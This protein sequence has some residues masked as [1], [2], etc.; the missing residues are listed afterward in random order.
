[1]ASE[2]TERLDRAEDGL[3]VWHAAESG[4]SDEVGHHAG[5]LVLQLVTVDELATG[6]DEADPDGNRLAVVSRTV[7]F[8]PAPEAGGD[9]ARL[10][11]CGGPTGGRGY[12]ASTTHVGPVNVATWLA[13]HPSPDLVSTRQ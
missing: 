11:E 9:A 1:M 6:E 2:S 10:S 8:Q 3:D 5:V 4:G 13:I 7:S 12:E